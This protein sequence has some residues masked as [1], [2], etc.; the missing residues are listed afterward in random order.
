MG[1]FLFVSYHPAHTMPKDGEDTMSFSTQKPLARVLMLLIGLAAIGAAY[2]LFF[3]PNHI[4]P[5]GFSGL[6]IVLNHWFGFPVGVVTLALNAP[7]FLL[8]WKQRG[9]AYTLRSLVAMVAL[10]LL[11]DLPPL[12]PVTEDIMLS[13]V[14]GGALLGVGMGLVALADCSTGGTDT[15][16]RLLSDRFSG[17]SFGTTL[18]AIESVVVGLSG[19]AFG[20]QSALYAALVLFLSSKLVDALQEGVDAAKAFFIITREGTA[21]AQK[22]LTGMRRGVTRL[23]GWGMY[24][25]KE[26]DV[27]LCV[28]SRTETGALKSLVRQIDPAAFVIVSDVREALG[29]GFRAK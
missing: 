17:M 5:G 15:L 25:G 4:A 11:L 24:S 16:A 28:I 2:N 29:E 12:Y 27:L 19:F 7:L 23:G 22:I 8:V 21:L 26:L 14:Y 6:G 13:S 10:S 1:G 18:L 20:A 9:A 3:I